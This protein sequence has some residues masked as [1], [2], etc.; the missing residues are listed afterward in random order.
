MTSGSSRVA[1]ASAVSVSAPSL[2][3]RAWYG[4]MRL[5]VGAIALPYFRLRCSGREH[6][7]K[8][9]GCL[10]LANHQSHLDPP[11]TGLVVPRQISYVAR[12]T[13]FRNP[14]LGAL[15]R[16]LNAVPIDRDG[17]GLSGLKETMRRLKR[18]EIVLLFPEGTRTHDGEVGALRPGF[19]AL[20]QRCGVPIVPVGIDGAFQAWPRSAKFPHPGRVQIAIGAP[21]P[22]EQTRDLDDRALVQLV[23]ERLRACH[24]E[25]RARRTR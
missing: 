10:L 7:P 25:A 2:A 4:G 6:L 20:V 14:I 16:S 17:L 3:R 24:A 1:R 19:S 8:A 18:G 9:G 23:E 22:I 13:L 15:L 21:I 12:E 5:V 11:L